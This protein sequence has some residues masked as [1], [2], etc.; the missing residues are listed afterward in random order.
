MSGAIPPLPQYASTA[1]CSV[2]TQRQLYLLYYCMLRYFVCRKAYRIKP[3]RNM[4]TFHFLFQD[5]IKEIRYYA[6]RR[7]GGLLLAV[8]VMQTFYETNLLH[9]IDNDDDYE[10]NFSSGELIIVSSYTYADL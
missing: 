2:K 1:W 9:N 7:T 3:Y 10:I 8:Y 4:Q 6:V 5:L